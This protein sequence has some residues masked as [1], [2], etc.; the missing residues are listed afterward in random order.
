MPGS[1]AV[2]SIGYEASWTELVGS[3]SAHPQLSSSWMKKRADAVVHHWLPVHFRD[4]ELAARFVRS[5]YG[6]DGPQW[7]CQFVAPRLGAV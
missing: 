2:L 7:R 4:G 1:P 3:L 5:R 6:P